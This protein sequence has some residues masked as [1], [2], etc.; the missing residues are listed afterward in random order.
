[1]KKTTPILCALLF[2]MFG[3]AQQELLNDQNKWILQQMVIDGTTINITPAPLPFW[4]PG[5]RFSGTDASN[6]NYSA[7]VAGNNGAFDALG[8]IVI[9]P[10]SFTIQFPTVTLGSCHPTCVL[11]S[12]YLYTIMSGNFDPQRT[13]NYEIVDEG[14]GR[15]KLTFTTP[16]GNTAIHGNYIL[17]VKRF[18]Q[19]KIVMYPNPVKKKMHFD[20]KGFPVEKI[21]I[22]SLTG[23]SIFEM[24]V[25]PQQNSLDLSFLSP[26][27][28][29]MK[30]NY[31][32]G[33]TT[34]SRFIK[35]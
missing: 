20:F 15:K 27:M 29:F 22:V 3:L 26:G 5:I 12:Q 8:P 18:D 6:Y 11:E 4:N 24:K 35:E 34:I 25:S 14:N 13:I 30:T 1:M 21:G 23:A 28:Y 33:D 31:Q 32:D 7:D 10:T 17:S 16:E 19:K 2:C 9:T